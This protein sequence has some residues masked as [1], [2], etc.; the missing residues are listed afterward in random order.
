MCM[1]SASM[2]AMT[3]DDANMD[4]VPIPMISAAAGDPS[5]PSSQGKM[6]NSISIL[7]RLLTSLLDKTCLILRGERASSFCETS[8]SEKHSGCQIRKI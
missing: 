8:G 2:R 7:S 1:V 4:Q 5:L 3:R 6:L